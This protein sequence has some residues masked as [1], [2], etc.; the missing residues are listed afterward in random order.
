MKRVIR[1]VGRTW[2]WGSIVLA[3]LGLTACGDVVITPEGETQSPTTAPLVSTSATPRPTGTAPYL[4]PAPAA[5]PTATPTPIVH[6]VQQGETLS[7]I[8][9]QYGVSVEAL[10]TANGIDNPLLLQ[11]GQELI[12]PTGEV[13]VAGQT[14]LLAPT[15]TPLP[16]GVR[17]VALYE[18]PVGSLDCY[19]EVVNTTP[20]TVTNVLVRVTLLDA[21]GNPVA[22][23]DAF[24]ASDVILP[25]GQAPFDRAPFRVLFVSPP[26][27]VADQ[28]VTLLRGQSAAALVEEI[29]P[30]AVE[31][32]EG[33]PVGP[34]FEVRGR[35]R[36]GEGPSVEQAVI[37]VTA[38]DAEG[39]VIGFRQQA[40][41]PPEGLSPGASVPFRLLL[42]VYGE[43]PADFSVVAY[44]KAA[45]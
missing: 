24:V 35:V 10:Q 33:A 34:Q 40:L 30:L 44:G 27:G 5:T 23:A 19:G 38:Y 1:Q 36:N 20:Y 13:D 43:V 31:G 16:L 45:D 2:M 17:G 4:P 12:I 39:R 32:A 8:A 14:G 18:T 28:R 3:V 21:A 15:P 26:P 11:A 25:A 41:A 22:A 7:G 42:T 9:A 37:G 29:L 6:I